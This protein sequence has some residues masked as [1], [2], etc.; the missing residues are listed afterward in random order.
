MPANKKTTLKRFTLNP[1][2]LPDLT[3]EQAAQLDAAPIDFSDVPELPE[4]FWLQ[5]STKAQ[6]TL[7]LDSDV[8][9]FFRDGGQRYQTR[10]NA[11]LRA[12]VDA[13][14]KRRSSAAA[15]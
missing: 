1:E 2:N 8:L 6:V 15:R 5:P 10:I 9:E 3:I 13:Q 14:R 11:V 12:F 4:A 7:R